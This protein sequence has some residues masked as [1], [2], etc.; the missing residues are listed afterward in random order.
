MEAPHTSSGVP[1]P[2][3]SGGKEAMV[4]FKLALYSAKFN[5]SVSKWRRKS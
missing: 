3:T 5:I 1:K 2:K 4:A